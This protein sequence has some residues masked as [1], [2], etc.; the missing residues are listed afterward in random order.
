MGEMTNVY[1]MVVG[2]PERKIKCGNLCVCK[3]EDN[4]KI[5]TREIE[6]SGGGGWCGLD[7]SDSGY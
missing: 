3:W 4:I 1:K 2:K 7:S 6:F 5:D